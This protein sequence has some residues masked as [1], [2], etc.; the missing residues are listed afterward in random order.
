MKEAIGG[1]SLF[2]IVIVF[3]L[4]FTGIMCLTIN[5]SKA[6][7]VKDEIINILENDRIP[8]YSENQTYAI[9]DDTR[10]EIIEFL[11]ENGYRITGRCPNEDGWIGYTRSGGI[12]DNSAAFCIRA[13]NISEAYKKDVEEKCKNDICK[14][15]SGDFP[16]IVYYDVI[17]FY[18]LD[19]PIIKY[20]ANLKLT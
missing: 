3:L 2:Q 4:L 7:G 16:S 8:S 9:S 12:N 13:N 14:P 10:D 18:Q 20:I 17:V 1:V 6:F 11:D 15:T 19:I 5:H